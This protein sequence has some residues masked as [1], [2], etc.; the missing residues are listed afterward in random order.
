MDLCFCQTYLYKGG[1]L[2]SQQINQTINA[3]L[4]ADAQK[5]FIQ[6]KMSLITQADWF[7]EKFSNRPLTLMFIYLP[8]DR[9]STCAWKDQN[10]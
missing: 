1:L 5:R 8:H 6:L 9:P 4:V 10:A 3:D 7:Q 2:E